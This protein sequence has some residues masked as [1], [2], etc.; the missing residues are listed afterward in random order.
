MKSYSA[1]ERELL[2]TYKMLDVGDDFIQITKR[3]MSYGD[4]FREALLTDEQ[5]LSFLAIFYE[6][7]SQNG[8]IVLRRTTA[9][10]SFIENIM[11]FKLH[12]VDSMIQFIIGQIR[13][14]YLEE[15]PNESVDRAN[16][17]DIRYI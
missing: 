13:T 9:L 7:L 10:T 14:V 16:V 3:I 15:E 12:S 4:S 2:E 8:H 5:V 17:A 6:K 11:L 1:V